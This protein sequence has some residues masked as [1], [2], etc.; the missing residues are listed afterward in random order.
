MTNELIATEYIDFFPSPSDPLTRARGIKPIVERL[1]RYADT[2]APFGKAICRLA[3]PC[4]ED[5][6]CR[7][8]LSCLYL[9][10]TTAEEFFARCG[11]EPIDRS[12]VPEAIRATAEFQSLCPASSVCMRKRLERST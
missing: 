12:R 5:R 9:L 11:Y 3:Q 8:H 6:A 7:L 2:N 1:R 4:I 10:T